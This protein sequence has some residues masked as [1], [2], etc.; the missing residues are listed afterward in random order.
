ME[1]FCE[2]TDSPTQTKNNPGN[3]P[4]I[5]H[6]EPKP[7]KELDREVIKLCSTNQSY[8]LDKIDTTPEGHFPLLP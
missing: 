8:L 1:E 5:N 4:W 3:L 7:I 6:T 2:E